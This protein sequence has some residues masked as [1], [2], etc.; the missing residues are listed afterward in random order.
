[1]RSRPAFTIFTCRG[2][3]STLCVCHITRHAKIRTIIATDTK[4]QLEAA[5]AKQI[6]Q[7]WLNQLSEQQALALAS[8]VRV[9][10]A[11]HSGVETAREPNQNET[12]PIAPNLS[13]STGTLESLEQILSAALAAEE[14]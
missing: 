12:P 7:D 11:P 8:L 5:E 4:S 14:P 13:V 6:T 10:N 1:M 3:S 9:F 2:L